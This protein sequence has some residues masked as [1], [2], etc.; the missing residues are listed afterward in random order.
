MAKK[1]VDKNLV[2]KLSQ[3]EFKK[4]EEK[5]HLKMVIGEKSYIG[6]EYIPLSGA[7]LH[8]VD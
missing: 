7:V 2:A 3:L 8:Q 1:V 5:V 6:E 4:G